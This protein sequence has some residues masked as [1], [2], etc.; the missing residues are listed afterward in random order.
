MN[1]IDW[2]GLS[3]RANIY[4]TGH[5][6]VLERFR[7]TAE[8]IFRPMWD[9]VREERSPVIRRP[10]ISLRLIA[11]GDPAAKLLVL[12]HWSKSKGGGH[13]YCHHL[14]LEFLTETA[15]HT[16]EGDALSWSKRLAFDILP[17]CFL[18]FSLP[19]MRQVPPDVFRLKRIGTNVIEEMRRSVAVLDDF[20]TDRRQVFA[21]S[22][23][24]CCVCGRSLADEQSK[25]R[26]IGPECVK[27]IDYFAVRA[28]APR[29][30]LAE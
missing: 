8:G 25:S 7:D 11:S 13:L 2:K 9:K 30:V 19:D 22:H 23:D 1:Q 18:A 20:L 12:P 27:G 10:N 16:P 28:A 5:V 4:L 26:G 24:N 17:K 14:H 15:V 21:R 3:K 29:L 6:E